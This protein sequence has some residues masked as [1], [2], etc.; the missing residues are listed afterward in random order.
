[1]EN[2]NKLLAGK[3][4]NSVVKKVYLVLLKNNNGK[5]EVVKQGESFHFN[6]EEGRDYSK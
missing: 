1:M 2:K 4:T 6:A 3:Y 5:E